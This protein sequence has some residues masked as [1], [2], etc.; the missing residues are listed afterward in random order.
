MWIV[1]YQQQGDDM[2]LS[3]LC[4]KNGETLHKIFEE[5][6]TGGVP[7]LRNE[8]DYETLKEDVKEVVENFLEGVFKEYQRDKTSGFITD[9]EYNDI[10]VFGSNTSG[11]HGKGAAKLACRWGARYGKG[12][13]LWG[14]TYAIPTKP[15]NLSRTLSTK[16]IAKYVESFIDYATEHQKL[17]FLVTEIGCGLAGLKPDDVA[18]MFIRAI[19]LPNVHLPKRFWIAIEKKL[20]RNLGKIAR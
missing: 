16:E 11:R 10:F 7:N 5:V 9:L 18:P 8:M 20:K 2:S 4:K 12:V 17:N 15:D 13:G 14:R 3:E 1:Y 19:H 6:L